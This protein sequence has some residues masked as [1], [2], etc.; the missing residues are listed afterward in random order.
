MISVA[1]RGT[2]DRISAR[3][4]FKVVRAGSGTIAIYS[5][6]FLG[7]VLPFFIRDILQACSFLIYAPDSLRPSGAE[8]RQSASG[9]NAC[10]RLHFVEFPA[11]P[12]LRHRQTDECKRIP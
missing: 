9:N 6:V 4:F 8:T 1:P 11:S 10:A 3:I 12:G 2:T 5:S 7:R